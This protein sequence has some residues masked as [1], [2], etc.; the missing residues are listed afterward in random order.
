MKLCNSMRITGWALLL[1]LL[2]V[3][4]AVADE[5]SSV[6]ARLY[7]RARGYENKIMVMNAIMEVDD[8][9][10]V[11]FL[12]LALADL[13][14]QRSNLATL[15]E[16]LQHR[17]LTTMIV[18]K[19]GE[20][21]AAEYADRIFDVLKQADDPYL[22][23]EAM[24]ALGRTTHQ[25]YADD[26]ALM[27]NNLN[28]NAG[29]EAQDKDSEVLAL[30][31][32]LALERFHHPVGYNPLF[33]AS[34][35]WYSKLS[36]VREQAARVLDALVEDP[37]DILLE[38]VRLESQFGVKIEALIAEY[39]SGAEP[40]RKV[41]VAVEALNQGLVGQPKNAT[42]TS[43]LSRLRLTAMAIIKEHGPADDGSI[44]HLEKL[45]YGRYEITEQLT[46]LEVL[47]FYTSDAAVRT[48]IAFL[49]RQNDRQM[50]GISPEDYRI[51]R[52]TIRTL[53]SIGNA[54]AFEELS[55]VKIS[56]SAP[57][58]RLFAPNGTPPPPGGWGRGRASPLTPNP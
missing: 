33:F 54:G 57:N 20:L 42:E 13:G 18:K 45:L 36:T 31:A 32:I 38:L 43:I 25:D 6:W 17:A 4:I 44:K 11:H 53:G 27:L 7:N 5:T 29:A 1:V 3:G 51:I 10:I 12:G 15:T 49:K 16:R 30:A 55:A 24:L 26:I 23:G 8:P 19:L 37:T 56:N 40:G 52:A 2:S 35:G 34:I 58:E 28:L 50:S 21:H 22:K 41:Q 9:T 48:V 14:E 39:R 46:A 47:G